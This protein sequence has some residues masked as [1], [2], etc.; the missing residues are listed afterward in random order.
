MID[1][2]DVA[3]TLAELLALREDHG[4]EGHTP[5]DDD[6][7][8]CDEDAATLLEQ[9]QALAEEFGSDLADIADNEP[10]M[11]HERYF[12]DYAMELADDTGAIDS[13]AGWPMS[14]IDWDQAARELRMDYTSVS[15]GGHDYW[16]RGY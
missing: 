4:D 11:I 12:K 16:T 14:C 8:D 7:P 13:D 2:R 3:E 10:T 9:I 15:F 6:C 1:L 5:A